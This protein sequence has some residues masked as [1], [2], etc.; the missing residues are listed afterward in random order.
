[1]PSNNNSVALLNKCKIQM[2]LH[3]PDLDSYTNSKVER[4]LSTLLLPPPRFK[5]KSADAA[6]K[7]CTQC[8]FMSKKRPPI[9]LLQSLNELKLNAQYPTQACSAH[10]CVSARSQSLKI[11]WFLNSVYK[12]EFWHFIWWS[13]RQCFALLQ[14]T[15]HLQ[16]DYS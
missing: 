8:L 4:A 3:L 9:W 16:F 6:F 2:S 13:S 7:Q 5:K 12:F 11:S 1:M 15:G 10:R 14:I